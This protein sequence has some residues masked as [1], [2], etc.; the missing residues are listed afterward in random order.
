LL[1][2]VALHLTAAGQIFLSDS[3]TPPNQWQRPTQALTMPLDSANPVY[4]NLRA[5][6]LTNFYRQRRGQLVWAVTGRPSA[7][8]DSLIDLVRNSAYY[9]L[10]P[11]DYHLHE[12]DYLSR[13][14]TLSEN[15]YRLE[16]L[17][18]DA[19]LAIMKDIHFGKIPLRSATSDT[20]AQLSLQQ[21]ADHYGLMNVIRSAEPGNAMYRSL[22]KALA[23]TLDSVQVAVYDP[24]R[25]KRV[26]NLQVNIERSKTEITNNGRY[27]LVNIPSFMLYVIENDSV[28]FSSKI[29]VGR[30]ISPTP[31]L[32]ST[33]ECIITYPYWY[34]P[35]SIAVKEYLPEIK[36]N[37]AFIDRQRFDVLDQDGNIL[38][39]DSVPWN[40]FSRRN[41]PVV[42]RQRDGTDNSLGVLKFMFDNPYAIYLH[43]TNLKRLFKSDRRAFSH[44]CIR[45]ENA[46]ELAHYLIATEPV[47]NYVDIDRL[48]ENQTRRSIQLKNTIPIHVRYYTCTYFE[49][50]LGFHHDIYRKDGVILRHF[51]NSCLGNSKAAVLRDPAERQY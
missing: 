36:K 1:T 41:F 7:V 32:T 25:N 46:L 20:I 34:V 11:Q 27:I 28:I 18:T 16:A 14:L 3:A 4:D 31:E 43:D 26:Q 12:I 39:H 45:I 35:R 42:L 51:L 50:V 9:G 5:K 37:V 21:I 40:T 30:T 23:L 22:K 47:S 44:G 8:A 33:V 48:L 19:F 15:P 13:I 2:M 38:N 49:D 24:A 10:S 6:T 17:L 29:I